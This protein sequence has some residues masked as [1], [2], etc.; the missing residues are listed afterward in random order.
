MKTQ[1]AKQIFGL[2]PKKKPTNKIN[3][4]MKSEERKKTTIK[5]TE[6]AKSSQAVDET[7]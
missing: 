7:L 6:A 2:K 5:M 1:K 3:K 4:S